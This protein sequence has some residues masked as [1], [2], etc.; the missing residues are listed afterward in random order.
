MR[1][2][3]AIDIIGGKCVRLTKGNYNTK[4][5]YNEN[6]LEVA[7]AFEDFGIKYLHIVDLDGAKAKKITNINIV[8]KILS[9]TKL[10]IDFGGGINH[11]EDAAL[12]FDIGV[13]QVTIGSI[14]VHKTELFLSMLEK[15]GNEKIILAADCNNKKIA[16]N[17][18]LET[19]SYDVLDYLCN[20]QKNGLK[21]AMVTDISKDG[22]LQ[23]PS[24]KLYEEIVNSCT[25]NLI[26]SG[27]VSNVN[28]VKNLKN[29]GCEAVIIGKAIYENTISLKELQSLID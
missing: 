13:A 2:I 20:Y 26:A 24:M 29:I 6:P 22:M 16:T 1:I 18:W 11:L 28:D 23:G 9:S 5:I 25:L 14:A 21:Y 17:A 7:Q 4:K 19:S 3:P 8:E 12:A 27:G 15:F 10:T